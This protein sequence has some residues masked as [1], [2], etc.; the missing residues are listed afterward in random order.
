MM[1]NVNEEELVAVRRR[2]GPSSTPLLNL[3]QVPRRD[4]APRRRHAVE[5]EHRTTCW[6]EVPL[7]RFVRHRRRAGSD[8]TPRRCGKRIRRRDQLRPRRV[9]GQLSPRTPRA[10]MEAE[11]AESVGGWRKS[12]YRTGYFAWA[13][14]I[15]PARAADVAVRAR[16]GEAKRVPRPAA[17]AR[18]QRGG[19]D[20]GARVLRGDQGTKETPP[21]GAT[22]GEPTACASRTPA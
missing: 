10:R 22:R 1:S 6:E 3:I 4:A 16:R 9:R 7:P 17:A 5:V 20:G 11:T 14:P 21:A 12:E 13:G 2:W 8:T 19:V 18:A 15:A